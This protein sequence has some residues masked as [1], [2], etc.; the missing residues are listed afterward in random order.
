MNIETKKRNSNRDDLSLPIHLLI[1]REELARRVRSNPSYSLRSFAK[2]LDLDASLLSKV[3]NN[4]RNLSSKMVKQLLEKLQL[5][6]IEKEI[7]WK[8]FIR[9]KEKLPS[10]DKVKRVTQ[11]ERHLEQDLFKVIADPYHYV[12]VEMSRIQSFKSDIDWI[13]HKLNLQRD[14]V[15]SAIERLVQLGMLIKEGSE[16]KRSPGR[17]TTKDKSI[18]DTAHKYHQRKLLEDGIQALENV[19]IE[20]RNQTSMTIAIN[21]HKLPLAKV[22]MQEFIN[23]LADV[24][25]TGPLE[26]VY[27]ITLSLFPAIQDSNNKVVS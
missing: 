17:F 20:K 13:S 14:E 24:L 11:L 16:L 7:F 9:S 19:P 5:S 21:P 18:T 15:T 27:Q 25:E 2:Q 23:Q 10:S 6:E 8:S 12:L 1:L 3:L 4:S 26:E 22:M